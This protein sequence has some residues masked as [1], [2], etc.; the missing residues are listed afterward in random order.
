MSLKATQLLS[1]ELISLTNE[2]RNLNLVLFIKKKK[3][4]L[5]LLIIKKTETMPLSYTTFV[6]R[7]DKFD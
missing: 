7:V 2:L 6:I 3:K 4:N 5:V 1:L